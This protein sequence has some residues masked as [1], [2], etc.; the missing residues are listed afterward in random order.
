MGVEDANLIKKSKLRHS[1][2]FWL[3][4]KGLRHGQGAGWNFF[5]LSVAPRSPFTWLSVSIMWQ[6]FSFCHSLL[7]HIRHSKPTLKSCPVTRHSPFI[8]QGS[9]CFLS[10]IAIILDRRPSD[11][12]VLKCLHEWLHGLGTP[13]KQVECTGHQLYALAAKPYY[14][15]GQ[16]ISHLKYGTVYIKSVKWPR[17]MRRDFVQQNISL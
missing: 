10:G 15:F 1:L 6:E 8:W 2:T 14:T 3:L 4:P 7:C 5:Q 13:I 17:R 12:A 16:P 9:C 11:P